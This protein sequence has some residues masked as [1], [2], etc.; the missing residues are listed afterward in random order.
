MERYCIFE[1]AYEKPTARKMNLKIHPQTLME[2][3]KNV[4]LSNEVQHVTDP[5]RD[6]MVALLASASNSKIDKSFEKID[7]ENKLKIDFFS[8]C[9]EEILALYDVDSRASNEEEMY[10]TIL[11]NCL[12]T[13]V[14]RL[15][16]N[17]HVYYTILY[18]NSKKNYIN[19]LPDNW[20]KDEKEKFRSQRKSCNAYIKKAEGIYFPFEIKENRTRRI[21]IQD[22]APNLVRLYYS[23]KELR[24]IFSDTQ[25]D[26]TDKYY[27][28]NILSVYQSP[29]MHMDR[30]EEIWLLE[31]MLGINFAREVY[32]LFLPILP[33][34][35][36]LVKRQF[37]PLII[38]IIHEIVKLQ[39]VYSRCLVVHKLK[40]IV[41][42]RRYGHEIE[43]SDPYE[44]VL[45]LKQILQNC[46]NLISEE[47]DYREYQKIKTHIT[48]NGLDS[49]N[50]NCKKMLN[51][52]FHTEN[53]YY[54]MNGNESFIKDESLYSLIQK[55]IINELK[56]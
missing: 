22:F 44:M 55:A 23:N 17:M 37:Q 3:A 4:N 43:Q 9:N 7:E 45:Y 6:K 29:N 27:S 2:L 39:G 46:M 5:K 30:L 10:E 48:E 38:G 15:D 40:E 26:D 12:Q 31:R 11:F 54:I 32:S 36:S 41:K 53:G 28:S 49:L 52:Y 8:E 34:N 56:L 14:V 18:Q 24:N 51:E 47:F 19:L 20:T 21:R 25:S 35:F 13:P 33:K 16:M 1:K 50:N 42:I